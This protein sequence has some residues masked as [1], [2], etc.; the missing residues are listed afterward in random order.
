[1]MKTL[2]CLLGLFIPILTFAQD[3][4]NILW[5]TFEDTSP[6]FLGCYGNPW[7]HSPNFDRLAQEGVRFDRAYS[8]GAV[9]SPS[10][11]ALITGVRTYA[12]GTGC[13]RG[14]QPIP[15]F[16]TGFP[17]YMREVGYYTTN[18]KKTDYNT[19]DAKRIV[20][21]AWDE[22]SGK[23]GWWNR[24]EGQ[25]FFSVF[26][27]N[28][29]HQSRT[30]TNP[31]SFFE[32]QVLEKLDESEII[33][34]A[35]IDMPPFYF[36]SPELRKEYARIYH[37]VSLFDQQMDTLI[38]RLEREHLLEETIIFSFADHGEGMARGKTHANGL[39]YRVPFIM[40]FPEKYKHL[41]PWGTGVVTEEM[42]S[43]EDLAPTL[44]SLAGA[45]IPEHLKGRPFLGEA[46][47]DSEGWLVHSVDRTGTS[48]E[49]ARSVT[50]GKYVYTRT[51]MPDV[52]EHRW[53]KYH[54]YGRTLQLLRKAHREGLMNEVQSRYFEPREIEYLYDLEADPWEIHNLAND[55]QHQAQLE[56]MR[57]RLNTEVL[58]ARDIHFV[59]EY[60]LDQFSD[61]ATAYEFRESGDYDFPAIYLTAQLVG[62]GQGVLPMQLAQLTHRDSI[63]RYWA[64]IGL[65]Q[66]GAAIVAD[67]AAIYQAMEDPFA[68]VQI[69]AA[70]MAFHYLDEERGWKLLHEHAFGGQH[71]LAVQV[72]Q[73]LQYSPKIPHRLDFVRELLAFSNERKDYFS[74]GQLCE[75]IL[76]EHTGEPLIYKDFW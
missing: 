19:T 53:Q 17:A 65:R 50:M 67:S 29:T 45:E 44:L 40:W 49:L 68:P 12:M 38:K 54:D 46:R 21:E 22:S 9:C 2:A 60:V 5:L 30:M 55:P 4:P 51:F 6:H 1:M 63:V 20:R 57:K 36:E 13:H 69:E 32:K 15:D 70:L 23:A 34:E 25:P 47:V 14:P 33:S 66:Q 52:P 37:G 26:N 35:E 24:A 7:V 56:R 64:A 48:P 28:S 31:Y 73:M 74:V 11:S 10:R 16:I 3:R 59:P 43:F 27:F 42:V 61:S 58:A 75:M 71:R 72:M 76:H 62:Q 18:N 8:T 39:G 41:S